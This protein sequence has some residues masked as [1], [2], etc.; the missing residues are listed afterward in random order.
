MDPL[1]A[2]LQPRIAAAEQGNVVSRSVLDIFIQ[3][4]LSDDEAIALAKQ[5]DRDL[6]KGI[7]EPLAHAQLISSL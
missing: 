7:A 3:S 1:E 6:E 2:F 5:R 4:E